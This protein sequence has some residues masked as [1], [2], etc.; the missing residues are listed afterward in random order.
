[1]Q[2]TQDRV[3]SSLA[4]LPGLRGSAVIVACSGGADSV[5]LLVLLARLA[6][7]FGY[8]LSILTVDHGIRPED[9]SA[10]DARFV[11]SLASGLEPPVPC[12]IVELGRGAV[13]REAARRGRGI[14][15]AARALRYRAIDERASALGAPYVFLGHT[16]TDQLET[17]L[18]RVLQGSVSA[19]GIAARRGRIVRPLLG[20]SRAEIVAFLEGAGVPWRED[21]T[22]ADTRF[23]RNRIRHHLVPTLDR[24]FPGWGRALLRA[25]EKARVDEAYIA[26]RPLPEWAPAG[27]DAIR[28]DGGKFDRLHPALRLRLLHRGL[29]LLAVD[30][31]VPYPLLA[32]M[33]LLSPD[34]GRVSGSGLTLERRGGGVFFRADIVQKRKSGYLVYIVENGAYALPFGEITVTGNAGETRLDGALGPFSLPIVV[35]SRVAGDSV[36]TA[37]GGSKSVKKLMN[38]W[39][40]DERDRPLVPIVEEAGRVRAVYGSRLGYPDWYVR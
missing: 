16:R 22:N 34:T 2:S 39:S 3:R 26:S 33:S 11:E 40:V 29:G 6:P 4:S 31:R 36:E 27:D 19:T 30:R 1:M 15:E 17:L 35:R 14:E 21:R 25:A 5:A 37:D 12:E 23:L 7:E 28:V 9:E 38:D 8:R 32:R 13:E 20:V 18:M 10:G 24:D